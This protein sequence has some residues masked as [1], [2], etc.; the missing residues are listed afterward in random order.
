MSEDHFISRK[1]IFG[2]TVL[3]V[4]AILLSKV[5]GLVR[6]QIM[7]GYYGISFETDAFTWAY[8]IPNLFRRLFA[9]SL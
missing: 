9:E 1:R 4:L 7:T 8:F 2:A 6:D 5:S 3:V